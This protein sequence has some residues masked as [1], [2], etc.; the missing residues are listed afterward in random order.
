MIILIHSTLSKSG[1]IAQDG[2][3]S[4]KGI[5]DKSNSGRFPA[6]LSAPFIS[7]KAVSKASYKTYDNDNIIQE[8]LPIVHTL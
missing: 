1:Y 8:T 6:T 2:K 7:L 4:A 3:I 5:P